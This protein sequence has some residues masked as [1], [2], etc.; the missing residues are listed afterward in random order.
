MTPSTTDRRA[1]RREMRLARRALSGPERRQR[2]EALARQLFRHP[3]FR[4]AHRIGF[5]LAND[6]E[7][8]LT[9]LL[10]RAWACHKQC[11][12]PV[13]GGPGVRRMRFA[14]YHP[15]SPL[16][17][18]TFGIPEPDARHAV[19]PW[20]VDL[21]LMPLVAFDR[22]GGRLGMGG[23]FYDRSLDYRARRRVWT[24]PKL[25]GTAFDFQ[26]HPELPLAPWDVPLDAV[27]TDA[28]II[29]VRDA[30]TPAV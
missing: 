7:V 24:P 27:A 29:P 25:V 15:D 8:D 2:S 14:A 19:P 9:S 18:N 23:G 10:Q 21:L 12:L 28:A 20:G 6:G 22:C 5:Y 3:L 1:I 17:P 4:N 30:A 13:I 26:E 11:F 16:R